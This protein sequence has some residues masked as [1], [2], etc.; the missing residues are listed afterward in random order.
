MPLNSFVTLGRSGLH[1]IKRLDEISKPTLNFP[2]DFL[3]NTINLSQAGTTVNGIT[4]QI[5]PMTPANDA[6]RH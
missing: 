1:A 4:S 5:T 3:G 6:E 2:Y